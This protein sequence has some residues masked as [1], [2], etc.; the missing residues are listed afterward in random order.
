MMEMPQPAAEQPQQNV[1]S[2]AVNNLE[3]IDTSELSVDEGLTAPE[4]QPSTQIPYD[5][6]YQWQ[7]LSTAS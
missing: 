7:T 6:L 4:S 2:E 5:L 3:T 1:T